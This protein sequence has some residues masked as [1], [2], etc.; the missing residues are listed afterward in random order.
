MNFFNPDTNTASA[1]IPRLNSYTS[2]GQT[3]WEW[4]DKKDVISV[5]NILTDKMAN[6]YAEKIAEQFI[7]A[8]KDM[9]YYTDLT[10]K[11]E[12][13]KLREKLS[14]ERRKKKRWKNKYLKLV[15]EYNEL[16]LI[17][18]EACKQLSEE[19]SQKE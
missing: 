18:A 19:R 2:I 15:A 6:E 11:D 1:D 10:A 9:R 8:I 16:K 12:I 3:S 17:H 13:N 4:V 5:I 14:K 7:E